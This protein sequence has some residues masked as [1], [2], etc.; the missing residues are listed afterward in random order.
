MTT[1]YCTCSGLH[2]HIPER[3]I[4]FGEGTAERE[5]RFSFPS[6]ELSDTELARLSTRSLLFS[7]SPLRLDVLRRSNEPNEQDNFSPNRLIGL[8]T[9][10]QRQSVGRCVFMVK[11]QLSDRR[12][13]LFGGLG[14]CSLLRTLSLCSFLRANAKANH[15]TWDM[16]C[17]K[18]SLNFGR[19]HVPWV[20]SSTLLRLYSIAI[21]ACGLAAQILA[22]FFHS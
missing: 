6:P 22:F 2:A 15:S 12:H 13:V 8:R 17:S 14:S 5:L 9:F 18:P 10:M 21:C 20:G 19:R 4:F 3:K 7:K 16:E 11:K 1:L